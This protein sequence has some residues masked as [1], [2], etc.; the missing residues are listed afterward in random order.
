MALKLN[1]YDEL[2]ALRLPDS[3]VDR[4]DRSGAERQGLRVIFVW[5]FPLNA[6]ANTSGLGMQE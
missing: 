3:A 1:Y 2:G 4:F 5:A 6:D